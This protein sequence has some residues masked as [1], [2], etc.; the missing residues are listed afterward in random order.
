MSMNTS[1]SLRSYLHSHESYLCRRGSLQRRWLS[2]DPV[3]ELCILPYSPLYPIEHK[4]PSRAHK[5][6]LN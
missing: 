1:H 5:R 4:G 2:G 3:L 6:G